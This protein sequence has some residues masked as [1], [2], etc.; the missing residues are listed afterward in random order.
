MK[1]YGIII[2]FVVACFVGFIG[3]TKEDNEDTN[4]I[5]TFTEL[6]EGIEAK[7]DSL[8]WKAFNYSAS[9][10]G[11][12]LVIY[13]LDTS[14]GTFTIVLNDTI[15]KSYELNSSSASWSMY[16][17]PHNDVYTTYSNTLAGGLV[18]LNKFNQ[19]SMIISGTFIF[20]V[21]NANLNRTRTISL[22]T[23]ANINVSKELH[24]MGSMKM[25]IDNKLWSPSVVK[26][27]LTD[28]DILIYASD[29]QGQSVEIK[30]CSRYK[31]SYVID[32]NSCHYAKYIINNSDSIPY[33]T[34]SH[35]IGSGYVRIHNIAAD[36]TI[37]GSLTLTLYRKKDRKVKII[38][39]GFFNGIK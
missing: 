34:N 3:C 32:K 38:S 4:K 28:D 5:D 20:Y 12:Q 30:I 37:S 36:T 15:L 6:K 26:T 25:Q 13:G 2:L 18:L 16:I 17:T 33:F 22:G 27:L 14:L 24:T 9:L 19:D 7:I 39:W 29:A 35:L 8:K 23:F 1:N 31:G 21:Y 10:Y 11:K